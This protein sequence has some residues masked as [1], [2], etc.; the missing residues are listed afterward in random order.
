MCMPYSQIESFCLEV[1]LSLL[2]IKE[3][4]IKKTCVVM[5]NGSILTSI[6]MLKEEEEEEE[7]YA[8]SV[9]ICS[10]R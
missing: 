2:S 9:L 10:N 3:A 7:R 1:L 5:S 8:F 4:H 6:W